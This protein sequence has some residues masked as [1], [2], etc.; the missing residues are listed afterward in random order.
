M[1]VMRFA[2]AEVQKLVDHAD[3]HPAFCPSMDHLFNQKFWRADVPADQRARGYVDAEY[4]DAE[5]IEP[6]LLL[7][8]D[9]G[10]YLMSATKETLSGKETQGTL[11]YCVYAE[12]LGADADY[13]D[14]RAAAGGDDFGIR[15]PLETV[16][17]MIDG[18][19]DF[20]A[21]VRGDT[22]HFKSLKALASRSRPG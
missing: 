18:G 20:G 19:H 15:V 16:R 13:D 21:E 22:V 8:K 4:V 3:Q 6:H 12:G 14:I 2:H 17:A 11:N 7:V 10:V 5:K 1:T 9:A